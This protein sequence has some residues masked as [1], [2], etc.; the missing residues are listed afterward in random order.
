MIT[1]SV[2]Q[3]VWSETT[4]IAHIGGILSIFFLDD[5]F[6]IVVHL[7]PDS[8]GLFEGAGTNR[9]DHEFLHGKFVSCMRAAVDDI[10]GLVE[11]VGKK[12]LILNEITLS[13]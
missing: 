12:T 13:R 10:K 6:Q 1:L 3:D 9:Q 5:V 11:R 8:H 7:S 2:L 4:F